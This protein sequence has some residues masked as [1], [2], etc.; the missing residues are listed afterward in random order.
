M[1][2]ITTNNARARYPKEGD[3]KVSR[4]ISYIE[5]DTKVN[6]FFNECKKI[7]N[8]TLDC[9]GEDG[10]TALARAVEKGNIDLIKNI[11]KKGGKS[12]LLIVNDK[13]A[14]PLHIATYCKDPQLRYKVAIELLKLEAPVNMFH[15]SKDEYL[16]YSPLDSAIEKDR[17]NIA[18]LFLRNGGIPSDGQH[19]LKNYLD[20][21]ELAKKEIM[22]PNEKLFRLHFHYLPFDIIKNILTISAKLL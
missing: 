17:I 2:A 4:V 11:V 5:G 18:V 16:R 10:Y 13:L 20:N 1:N 14:S 21:L 12:L 3:T 9:G 6:D 19:K 15:P 8:Y 7:A 22:T